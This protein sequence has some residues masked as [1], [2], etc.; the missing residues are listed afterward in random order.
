MLS[1]FGTILQMGIC[2]P[3][4]SRYE[5]AHEANASKSFA[6]FTVT[7]TNNAEHQFHVVDFVWSRKPPFAKIKEI[8][9][10]LPACRLAAA[11][12]VLKTHLDD[13]L[14][15]VDLQIGQIRHY[16]SRL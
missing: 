7:N 15:Y 3:N 4:S 16:L 8:L 9:T 10:S 5:D 13:S 14:T 1:Q 12:H 6:R 11:K 2:M